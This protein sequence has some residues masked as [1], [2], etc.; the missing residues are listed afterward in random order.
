MKTPQ[1]LCGVLRSV[2]RAQASSRKH[3]LFA[4]LTESPQKHT[5][6][7]KHSRPSSDVKSTPNSQNSENSK[8][9]NEAHEDA[10]SRFSILISRSQCNAFRHCTVIID[11][12]NTISITNTTRTSLPRLPFEQIAQTALGKGYELS[13]VLIGDQ[14]SQTLNKAHRSVDKP[15]SVLSFPLDEQAGEIY[16]NLA[17]CRRRAKQFGLSYKDCVGFHFIHGILHLKGLD[18]GSTMERREKELCKQF[19]ISYPE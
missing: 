5:K 16:L 10:K 15:A 17:L 6:R 1:A 8:I 11:E 4:T 12:M 2:C 19:A 7:S 3:D 9:R 18:H 14:R 13:F